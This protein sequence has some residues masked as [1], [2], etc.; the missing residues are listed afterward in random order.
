MKKLALMAVLGVMVYG[1]WRWQRETP[2]ESKASL[3]FNRFWVD[4]LPTGERD[5]FNVLVMSTPESIG[6]FAEETMWNGRIERFR[7]DA[8]GDVIRAVFPY[9]GDRE[10]ITLKATKCDEADMDFCLEIS[11]SKRGVSRYYSRSG[12]ERRRGADITSFRDE[13][14]R[15]AK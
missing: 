4:H 15:T 6:G 7:F 13:L 8:D 12:W 5:P 14:L 2:S 10:Q 9:T 11:G 3:A 1:G